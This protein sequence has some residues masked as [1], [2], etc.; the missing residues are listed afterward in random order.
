LSGSEV[1]DVYPIVWTL[2]GLAVVEGKARASERI[3]KLRA[4]NSS[5]SKART[6]RQ[7]VVLDVAWHQTLI[8]SSDNHRL[9]ELV[10]TLKAVVQRYEIAYMAHR[11][12]I[13]VSSEEHN[14][15]TRALAGMRRNSSPS[16]PIGLASGVLDDASVV[17]QS[18]KLSR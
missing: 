13:S 1:R 17:T 5:L 11:D 9:I 3:E 15:I 14:A 12:V 4:I 10:T 16:F 7:R 18:V 2:E 6:A 8:A